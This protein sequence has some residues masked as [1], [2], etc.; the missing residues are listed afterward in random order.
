[1]KSQVILLRLRETIRKDEQRIRGY[2]LILGRVKSK[3]RRNGYMGVIAKLKESIVRKQEAIEF[4]ENDQFVEEHNWR[5]L[6]SQFGF[7]PYK[8]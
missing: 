8:Q 2:T 7:R 6:C 1:M 4:V 3:D 5:G